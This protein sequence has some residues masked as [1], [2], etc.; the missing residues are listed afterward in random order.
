M[1]PTPVMIPGM[2]VCVGSDQICHPPDA[3]KK[4]AEIQKKLGVSPGASMTIPASLQGAVIVLWESAAPV[5]AAKVKLG[6]TDTTNKQAAGSYVISVVGYPMQKA[7][8]QELDLKRPVS[9]SVRNI[10]LQSGVLVL[11]GKHPLEA[12]D[13][14]VEGTANAMNVRYFFP[15]DGRISASEKSV[16]FR[17]QVALGDIVEADFSPKTMVYEGRSAMSDYSNGPSRP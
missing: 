17:M 7:I 4:L 14:E 8:G 6:L 3:D 13:I 12:S 2:G 16:Q 11:K 1:D 5:R 9:A 15:V 10:I